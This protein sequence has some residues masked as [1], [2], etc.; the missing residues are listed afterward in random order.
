MASMD[1]ES[2]PGPDAAPPDAG[3]QRQPQP[4]DGDDAGMPQPA[5][6]QSVRVPLAQLGV[7]S[8]VRVRDVLVGQDELGLYALS[9]VCPHE[10]CL[11]EPP[12]ASG[13][14]CAGAKPD[15]LVCPCHCSLFDAAG[16]YQKGPATAD[17]P[18]LQLSVE[19]DEVVVDRTAQVPTDT[20]T[21]P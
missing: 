14:Q 18:H 12:G 8:V 5:P 16:H 19:G 17:L 20:R 4:Q 21:Q 9:A 11:V 2:A 10:G 7:G 1:A 6:D 15:W 3:S 13:S